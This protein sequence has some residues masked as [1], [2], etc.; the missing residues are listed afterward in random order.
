MNLMRRFSYRLLFRIKRYRRLTGTIC[1]DGLVERTGD[2]VCLLLRCK[3]D[4]VY[5]VTG[6]TDRQ[7][8]IVLGML[9]SVQKSISVEYVDVE[10]MT[11]LG[12]VVI[13]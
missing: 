7:L 4:E 11:A 1:L 12:C 5:C 8:R 6:N 2:N 13:Q 10:V 9:L 3:L